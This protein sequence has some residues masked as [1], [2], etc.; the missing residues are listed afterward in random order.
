[1]SVP[2]CQV[3]SNLDEYFEIEPDQEPVGVGNFGTVYVATPTRKGQSLL[4]M[5]LK[6]GE[7]MPE[8]VAIKRLNPSDEFHKSLIISE[9]QM[10]STIRIKSSIKYYGCL[11]VGSTYY[12]IMEFFNSVELFKLII[13]EHE[14]NGDADKIISPDDKFLIS[15]R[16]AK[17]LYELHLHGIVHRDLKPENILIDLETLEIKIID[18]GFSCNILS[19]IGRCSGTPGTP[20]YIDPKLYIKT[21]LASDMLLA[22]WW[23]FGQIVYA[24]YTG[25][26]L[27]IE[28]RKRYVALPAK[29]QSKF[30]ARIR[31]VII[32]LTNPQL[33]PSE[34][35]SPEQILEVFS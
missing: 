6:P 11:Q 27:Y 33:D 20:S 13:D 23:A 12:I 31:D 21:P 30:P 1:M 5:K 8:I 34:R 32:N 26:Q 3:T 2:F 29:D 10:L 19:R 28:S 14:A 16:I 35:P 25:L 15:C 4:V 7:P 18:Y 24:L 22:D 9:I 17:A